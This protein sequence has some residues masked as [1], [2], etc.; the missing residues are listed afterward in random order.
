M[1]NLVKNLRDLEIN[2]IYGIAGIKYVQPDITKLTKE[3][4]QKAYDIVE[5]ITTHINWGIP[6]EKSDRNIAIINLVEDMLSIC[7]EEYFDS[8]YRHF[9]I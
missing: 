5:D 9:K 3:D 4:L 8:I 6:L 1:E 2:H 7:E